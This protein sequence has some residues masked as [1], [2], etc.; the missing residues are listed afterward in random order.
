MKGNF[1]SLHNFIYHCV[2]SE[3]SKRLSRNQHIM[4]SIFLFRGTTVGFKGNE[5]AIDIPYTQYLHSSGKGALVW[6]GMPA[7]VG[8]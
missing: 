6:I 4:S 2:H 7:E 1:L 3:I 5:A 8:N